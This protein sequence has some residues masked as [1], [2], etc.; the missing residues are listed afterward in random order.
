MWLYISSNESVCIYIV[1]LLK[2][3]YQS[4]RNNGL[5]ERKYENVN[6]NNTFTETIHYT[7]CI[8]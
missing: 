4:K 1:I 6:V 7:D 2:T 3:L 8:P 5:L